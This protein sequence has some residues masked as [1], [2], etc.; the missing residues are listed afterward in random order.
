ME[1][2]YEFYGI[3]KNSLKLDKG[4]MEINLPLSLNITF[5][6]QIELAMLKEAASEFPEIFNTSVST[7][8]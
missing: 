4:V 3:C 8:L 1:H 5:E 2:F 6:I 7:I